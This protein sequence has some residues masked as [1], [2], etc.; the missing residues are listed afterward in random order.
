MKD[1]K[2]IEQAFENAYKEVCDL[3]QRIA[4]LQYSI[5]PIETH[6]GRYGQKYRAEDEF[7][8]LYSQLYDFLNKAY[9]KVFMF[10]VVSCN[11][12]LMAKAKKA[13]FDHYLKRNSEI[14]SYLGFTGSYPCDLEEKFRKELEFLEKN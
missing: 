11:R 3:E 14:M 5:G 9:S 2:F 7:S 6:R 12:K 4:A 8:A 1:K 13:A 10:G